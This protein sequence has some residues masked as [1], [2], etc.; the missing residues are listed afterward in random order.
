MTAWWVKFRLSDGEPV[1]AGG[2]SNERKALAQRDEDHGVLLLD[3]DP[4]I[5]G[6][7]AIDLEIV[8]T[9]LFRMH[10]R[11]MTGD[12]AEMAAAI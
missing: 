12:L 11:P 1:M 9:S 5:A 3:A 8:R 2:A 4:R 6:T 7:S 10:G